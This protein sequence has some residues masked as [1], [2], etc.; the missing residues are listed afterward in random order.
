MK[1]ETRIE[2][3]KNKILHFP[4]LSILIALV[5]L[6]IVCSFI[7]K[8]FFTFDNIINVLRQTSTSTIV[9]VGMTFALILGGIDL[10]VGSIACLAGI[11]ASGLM[12][13]YKAG[14]QL[15]IP[16]SIAVALIIGVLCGLVNGVIITRL[17]LSPFIVTLASMSTVRG[18]ALL[19]SNGIPVARLPPE[20]VFLGRGYI[21]FLPIPVLVMAVVIALTWTALGCM[22][23]GRHVQAIGG[24]EECA[25][26]SGIKVNRTKIIVYIIS[27]GCAAIT[28][29]LL[30]LRLGSGQPTVAEGME[31]DAIT[32]VVLGGTSISGG[33]G[34]MLGTIIG[35]LFLTFLGNG[36]NIIGISSFWQRVFKGI[37]LVIAIGLYNSRKK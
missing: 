12:S 17:K 25:R 9:A 19:Y 5:C 7:S 10:S 28:G 1:Q 23:F 3:I 32:A 36:F 16:L 13:G 11:F 31:M 30:T 15:S 6:L 8:N 24:N 18:L 34:Y 20:A 35:C 22:S 4:Q 29:V 27:G 37:I 26:L 21:G 33:K 2:I 14:F